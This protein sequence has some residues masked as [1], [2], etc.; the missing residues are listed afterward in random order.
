M[1]SPILRKHSFSLLTCGLL[2]CSSGMS[3]NAGFAEQDLS[4]PDGNL[5]ATLTLQSQWNTGYCANVAITNGGTKRS[6]SWS[7]NV[8]LN[9]SVFSNGWNAQLVQSTGQLSGS[10]LN[11][12]GTLAPNA[13][14]SWG[15]CANGTTMPS[16]SSVTG[17]GGSTGAGGSGG[18]GGTTNSGGS[19]GKSGSGGTTSTGGSAG[20][21]GSGGST[22]AGGTSAGGS[23]G[24]GCSGPT[25]TGGTQHC[26][27]NASG[28]VGSYTWTIWSSGSGGC[29][30]PYGTGAAYKATW[31]NAGDFLAREGLQFDE[32]KTFD[33]Y[34]TISADFAYT[35]TGSGGGFSFIGI[36]G[37]S[38]NPLIEYYIVDDWYGSGPP[39]GGGTKKGSFTVDGA[40]YNVY[41][42]TQTNQPSIHGTQTFQQFFSVRQTARQCGHIS[43]SEHFKE[44]ASLGMNLGK[45]YESKILVEVGGGSGSIDFT[46]ASV[47]AK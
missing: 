6:T 4:S 21:A 47:T 16:L 22:S 8:A 44:W 34:G 15:F 29:M 18:S 23:A 28:T 27:S 35:K 43:I 25:L 3:E 17:S 7:V 45:M 12:N 40:T 33:Q 46:T 37:W 20:K 38:N 32:T 11:Y 39:T 19:A 42:H 31:N 36:Y 10:N 26:S 5:S 2:A 41:T 14:T 13:S 24:R 30:T 1:R 9:G